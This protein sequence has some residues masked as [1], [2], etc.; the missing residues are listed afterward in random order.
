PTPATSA[1]ARATT[2]GRGAA[3]AR[4]ADC[5]ATAGRA[6][7]PRKRKGES[8]DAPS[9][10]PRPRARGMFR[11]RAGPESRAVRDASEGRR[12]GRRPEGRE[13][14]ALRL[15]GRELLLL[16]PHLEGASALRARRAA[17]ALGAG[18]VPEGQL[19][20]ARRRGDEREGPRRR[21]ARER[22]PL[23]RE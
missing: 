5:A 1:A 7:E 13:A 21:A 16:Q 12:G 4:R 11:A 6:I 20:G 14:R 23:P 3:S 15:L 10:R 8:H 19:G 18:R 9:L 17:G 2:G 22:D